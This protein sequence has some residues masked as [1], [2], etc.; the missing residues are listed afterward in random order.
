MRKPVKLAARIAVFVLGA[1]LLFYGWHKS[2]NEPI[3]AQNPGAGNTI[4]SS[5]VLVVIGGFALLMTFLP[6]SETLGRWMSLKHRR[7]PQA[8]HFKRRRQGN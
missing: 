2:H 8:A 5:E 7:R 3:P 1:V 6:S 4:N